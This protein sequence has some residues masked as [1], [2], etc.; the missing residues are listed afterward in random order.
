MNGTYRIAVSR[1]TDGTN[2]QSNSYSMSASSSDEAC[3]MLA[4]HLLDGDRI[5]VFRRDTLFV[6][7]VVGHESDNFT[8]TYRGTVSV[9]QD[10]THIDLVDT[11]SRDLRVLDFISVA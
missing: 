7:P 5:T 9:N 8:L 3:R 2:G 10:G 6:G 1:C 4:K 11:I